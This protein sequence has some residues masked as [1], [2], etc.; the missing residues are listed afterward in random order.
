MSDLG[1]SFDPQIDRPTSPPPTPSWRRFASSAGVSFLRSPRG[2]QWALLA[3]PILLVLP[4]AGAIVWYGVRPT[5]SFRK[6]PAIGASAGIRSM[7]V[8]DGSKPKPAPG[9]TFQA[10]PP[11]MPTTYP[12]SVPSVQPNQPATTNIPLPAQ[13]MAGAV[14]PAPIAPNAPLAPVVPAKPPISPL[15]YRAKHDKV[16]GGS[17]SGQLTLNSG[18]LVFNC[19]DDPQGSVQIALSEIGAVDD[20]GVRLL[21]GKK[22][23][24]SIPGMSKSGEETLFANWLHQ[25]R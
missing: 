7:L 9:K 5:R 23:H 20:N 4:V 11:P 14:S 22:Y 1:S 18:G 12:V 13:T 15:I 21:S 10:P 8:A 3:L 25:V 16:F 6:A 19:S 2:K 17:C 24:F